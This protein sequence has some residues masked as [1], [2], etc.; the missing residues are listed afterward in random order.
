MQNRKYERQR[1]DL[2]KFGFKL[3]GTGRIEYRRGVKFEWKAHQIPDGP[4]A[5]V[6]LL[7]NGAVLKTG[8]TSGSLKSRWGGSIKVV[9]FHA[10]QGSQKGSLREHEKEHGRKLLKSWGTNELELWAKPALQITIPYARQKKTFPAHYAEEVFLD[11][12]FDPLF[13]Q[14]LADRKFRQKNGS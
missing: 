5:Y 1:K 13:G 9:N 7:R 10:K 6:A 14:P 12:H 11:D 3:C 2:D 8:V 4:C